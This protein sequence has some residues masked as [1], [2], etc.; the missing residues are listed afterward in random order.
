MRPKI[1]S[2]WDHSYRFIALDVETANQSRRSIC[3]IGL[4]GIATDGKLRT[5]GSLINPEE[6]FDAMNIG[7]HGIRPHMVAN[8]PRFDEVLQEWRAHLERFPLIQHSTFDKSAMDGACAYYDLPALRSNWLNSVT[9]ARRAW[10]EFKGNGGHGLANLKDELKLTFDHHD[11]IEDARAAAQIVLLAEKITGEN[12][13]DL[14]SP[15]KRAYPKS[16]SVAGK[17]SGPLFGHV[18][19]FT[20]KIGMSRT[21][22]ATIAANAGITVNT[23]VSKKVTL[24]VVGDQD[25]ELLAGHKKSS[26]HR[27]AEELI[28]E[29]H[30][31]RIIGEAEF[32]TLIDITQNTPV[33]RNAPPEATIAHG[34]ESAFDVEPTFEAA[35]PKTI[36]VVNQYADDRTSEETFKNGKTETIKKRPQKS[37]I[38]R[39]VRFVLW[40]IATLFAAFVALIIYFIAT[41]PIE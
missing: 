35:P 16:V 40:T 12:F 26:K 31:I 37:I 11:A 25:L 17:Q 36:K 23:S 29:G 21:E 15:K 9:I 2:F 34:P 14:A 32:M 24:L 30:S 20:G 38:W 5:T 19:V 33:R 41:T 39:I 10:P 8:A 18:V 27:R 7:I 4:A 1:P 13:V 22:A 6:Q 3:Q 28:E